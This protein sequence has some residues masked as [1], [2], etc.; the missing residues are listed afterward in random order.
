MKTHFNIGSFWIGVN[1]VCWGG[2]QVQFSNLHRSGTRFPP[3]MVLRF[4]GA[5][6]CA[7]SI[8]RGGKRYMGQLFSLVREKTPAF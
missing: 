5:R 2:A 3:K 8:L 4:F 7:S 6:K 1:R